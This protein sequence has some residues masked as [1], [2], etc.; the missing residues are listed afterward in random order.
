MPDPNT[1]PMPGIAAPDIHVH[2]MAI[3]HC[4]LC[5]TVMLGCYTC[6]AEQCFGAEEDD[7][8]EE[9]LRGNRDRPF[10]IRHI[11]PLKVTFWLDEQGNVAK[12]V[13]VA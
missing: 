7:D 9:M 13:E 11:D 5:D 8:V 3:F 1:D 12:L 2:I 6:H 4:E 10:T